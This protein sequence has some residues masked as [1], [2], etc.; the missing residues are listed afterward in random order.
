[1][2]YNINPAISVSALTNR[3]RSVLESD[4][5]GIDVQGE[6]SNFKHHSSGH[7]YFTLKDDK[8]QIKCVMWR[9]KYLSFQPRDGMQV[10]AKG[11][12]TVYP[13]QGNYQLDCSDLRPLGEGDLYLAYEALKAKLMAEGYFDANRKKA[14]PK[15]PFSIGISTS[16]TGAAVQDMLSTLKRRLP[17]TTVYFRPTLVQGEGSAEDIVR[18]IKDLEKTPAEII[19]IGRG[20]GSIEDLW[21][22][23]TEIVAKAIF[24]C[25]KPIISAVGHETDFTIAD[26]VADLRSPTPTAAAEL[27]SPIT[28]D[29]LDN[30]LDDSELRLIRNIGLRISQ[31][32]TSVIDRFARLA[33]RRVSDTL[34]QYHQFVDTS[35]LQMSNRIKSENVK[36][37]QSVRRLES[38]LKSLHP[39]SPFNKGFAALMHDGKY[40]D[41]HQTL[42][43]FDEIEIIRKI[44]KTNVKIIKENRI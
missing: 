21:S 2:Q 29:D 22:Y 38:H 7:R 30:F 10:I 33:T 37:S 24:D 43:D 15:L 32:K 23:N 39:L 28:I 31:Y 18:A 6:I 35:E 12:L 3:I 36:L 40:I 9:G 44:E 16:P 19:I 27:S 14:L 4:F 25:S 8:A 17:F 41:K 42:Q 34:N 13:P 11:S 1:M 5:V 20:G 26:F